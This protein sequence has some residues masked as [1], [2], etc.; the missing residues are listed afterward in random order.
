MIGLVVNVLNRP[1]GARCTIKFLFEIPPTTSVV[2]L[3]TALPLQQTE[4]GVGG[5]RVSNI[6]DRVFSSF[7]WGLMPDSK[8]LQRHFCLAHAGASYCASSYRRAQNPEVFASY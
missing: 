4:L 3:A 5:K 1:F 7:L 8:H 6:N 2:V